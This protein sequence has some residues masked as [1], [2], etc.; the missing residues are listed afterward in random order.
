M[1]IKIFADKLS[2]GRAAAQKAADAIRQAIQ[3]NGEARV[4]AATG[5]SQFEL[6]D[7]LT[8]QPGI[9]WDRVE[10]F[11]LDEYIGLP[12]THPASFRKYLRTR[13][14]DKVGITHSHLLDGEQDPADV[15]REV[16]AALRKSPI[17]IALVGIGENGHL[18]FN[19]PPADFETE[20]PYLVVMLDE[21]CRKQQLGEG[22]FTDLSEVPRQA[23]SMSIR[24][25]LQAREI[26]CC[27]SDA[28]KAHAVVACMEGEI[29]PLAPASIL[30]THPNTTIYLDKSAA[31]LL[32]S[33]AT[34]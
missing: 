23:I 3:K 30:R 15:I 21:A 10:L 18:A 8:S 4:I 5:A 17:D 19:D 25:I 20:E 12:A 27:V 26:I 34:T 24:Q 29:S 1:I 14:I 22:W 11:H 2:L 31:A 32:T 9:A 13:L 7:A 28:R 33:T 6:L 16:G